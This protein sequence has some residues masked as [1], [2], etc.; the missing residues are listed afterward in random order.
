MSVKVKYNDAIIASFEEGQI[1]TLKCTN[2]LMTSD[3]IVTSDESAGGDSK[4]NGIVE[5]YK[6]NVGANVSAGDFVEFVTKFDSF[7][8]ETTGSPAQMNICRINEEQILAVY[9]ISTSIRATIITF[10][11][12]QVEIG[13]EKVLIS[14]DAYNL[15][16]KSLS[17]NN[18]I[19][20][21]RNKNNNTYYGAIITVTDTT[22]TI[23]NSYALK[24]SIDTLW[25]NDIAVLSPTTVLTAMSTTIG[26]DNYIY[27]FLLTIDGSSIIVTKLLNLNTGSRSRYLSLTALGENKALLSYGA[28]SNGVK[29]QTIN[30]SGAQIVHGTS[31]TIEVGDLSVYDISSA[32]INENQAIISY[33]AGSAR[34][35]ALIDIVDNIVTLVSKVY[36]GGDSSDSHIVQLST[37]KFLLIYGYYVQILN[38]SDATIVSSGEQQL[39]GPYAVRCLAL[40]E[41]SVMGVSN[42]S[43]LVQ[44][45]EIDQNEIYPIAG[46]QGVETYIQPVTSPLHIGGVAKTSGIS[47]AK[48]EVYRPIEKIK[49]QIDYDDGMFYDFEAEKGM[50][51]GEFVDSK[52]NNYGDELSVYKSDLADDSNGNAAIG[53]SG[54]HL[55]YGY[56][57]TRLVYE[58]DI[59]ESMTYKSEYYN[60]SGGGS[61]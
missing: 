54:E 19:L 33:Y 8:I 55:Y 45:V 5:E 14:T 41:S 51:W 42:G 13:T 43:G 7:S 49:F 25:T 31:L 48:V 39:T 10:K 15:C 34:Y 28:D 60:V 53:V 23:S 26:S 18:F 32:K 38:I 20:T 46:I 58:N 22:I 36:I 56:D 11:D 30:V 37:T 16:V 61:N 2:S 9:D 50:T 21:H 1:A 47:G 17:L 44:C 4:I 52:Y 6:V 27:L 35:A 40:S 3:V 59:I 29:I 24:T 57:L 12:G